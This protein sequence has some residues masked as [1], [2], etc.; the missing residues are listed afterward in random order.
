MLKR[1]LAAML[2]VV[3]LASLSS[4][5]VQDLGAITI[6]LPTGWIAEKS[7]DFNY[8]FRT[9]DNT[10]AI[11]FDI[12]NLGGMDPKEAVTELSKK[13]SGSTPVYNEKDNAYTFTFRN[14]EGIVFT[15]SSVPFVDNDAIVTFV[16]AEV[17]TKLLDRI[18]SS[19]TFK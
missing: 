5:K 2:I 6:D 10:A 9:S 3:S 8:V 12:S 13:L 17:D 7:N 1:L 19:I 4:A 15:S 11:M 18:I 14:T 16:W